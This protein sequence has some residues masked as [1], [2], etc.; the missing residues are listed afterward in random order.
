MSLMYTWVTLRDI[1]PSAG[2]VLRTSRYVIEAI[3]DFFA[4]GSL[5]SLLSVRMVRAVV[6]P[7]RP[8]LYARVSEDIENRLDKLIIS[9]VGLH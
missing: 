9:S 1:N 4:V 2:Q 3:I 7:T 8:D 5:R 6:Y